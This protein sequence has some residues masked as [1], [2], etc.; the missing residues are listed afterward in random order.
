MLGLCVAL[1]ILVAVFSSQH[2]GRLELATAQQYQQ[3]MLAK[4]EMEQLSARLLE[5]EEDSRR[6]LSRELH[7]GIGQALAVMQI[8]LSHMYAL[9]SDD[10]PGMRE[11]LER[12]RQLSEKTVQTVR[13]IALLLRPALLDDL[14]LTPA[15]EWL[16][17][18]FQRRSG[19]PASSLKPAS[20][21]SPRFRQ[22]LRL[23]RR[24]GRIC[25]IARNTPERRRSA[26][27]CASRPACF[28]WKWKTTAAVWS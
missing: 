20:R 3:A 9:T 21:W 4:R 5:I 7:D 26:L 22:D 23:P 28:R 12:A 11:R 1:G 8:E 27:P 10:Q 6:R 2:A 16:L 15:L 13:N 17:E 18:D 24:S 19:F 25:T 14:G